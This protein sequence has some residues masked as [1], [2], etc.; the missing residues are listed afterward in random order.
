MMYK[1]IVLE[2]IQASP[3]YYEALR[4]SKRLLPAIESYANELKTRHHLWADQLRQANPGRDHRQM[5]AEAM[6]LAIQ[7]LQ[8]SL[9][10]ASPRDD[11]ELTL[12]AAI[13]HIRPLTPPA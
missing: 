1:T 5:A 6:E 4:S 13:S 8:E 9:P 12:D 2:L 3:A 7:D 11:M 10:Y